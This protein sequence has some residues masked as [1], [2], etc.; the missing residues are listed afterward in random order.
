[1]KQR[2]GH[3]SALKIT[4]GKTDGS[5]KTDGNSFLMDR[6]TVPLNALKSG[7]N[8]GRSLP[9]QRNES[10]PGGLVLNFDNAD[11]YEVVRTMAEI[12]KINYLVE[13]DISGA[14]TIHTA[15]QLK[16]D[17]LFYVFYQ[18]LEINGLT[19]VR[20]GDLYRIVALNEASRMP[21]GLRTS[22]D[23]G[24]ISHGERVIIQIVPLKFISAVEMTKIITPFISADGTIVSQADSNMMLL[25]DKGTNID[26]ALRLVKVFD[27]DIFKRVDHRL[28]T[29][30]HADPTEIMQTLN[31]F[32]TSYGQSLGKD[33]KLIE[34]GRLNAIMAISSKSE[35]FDK[36][37][38]LISLLDV[39]VDGY[40]PRIFIYNVRNGEASELGDLLS[41]IFS[42]K[43]ESPSEDK[44]IKSSSKKEPSQA[45]LPV[46]IVSKKE[47]NDPKTKARPTPNSISG[48]SSLNTSINI[49]PDAIR[50]ALIIEATPADYQVVLDV[51]K[52]LDVLPRQVLIEVTLAEVT[53]NDSSSLGV[54]WTFIKDGGSVADGLIQGTLGSTNVLQYNFGNTQKWAATLTALAS[55]GDVNIL[56]S[57]SVLASDNKEAKIDISTE[58]PVVTTEYKYGT[59]GDDML[60]T[61]IQYRN[62]GVILTV[63]P[64]INE[65]GL[66]SMEINQEVSE[67]ADAV[68]AGGQ[69]Y[70]S[71]YK[72]SVQ[73][74]LTV[75]DNQTIAIGGLMRKKEEDS[76]AGIPLLN[77]LP[78]FKYLFGKTAGGNEKNELII[79]ITPR[80]VSDL[81]DIDQVTNEF[82]QR[83]GNTGKILMGT[84]TYSGE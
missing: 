29:M 2:A 76:S 46:Q 75:N 56:S 24:E 42:G 83:V 84:G 69:E 6:E 37:D 11:L 13:K 63:T 66:V 35:I 82:R 77:Q 12:L 7:K 71:F 15:G 40:E 58:V 18:I 9:I 14:V 41:T 23:D 61:N 53:L 38:E 60:A 44:N 27:V 64:H 72:R 19:A 8:S 47:I 54:E 50:N 57:P 32:F 5:E 25:V 1:M 62:T 48:S 73:T 30:A 22:T 68:L 59:D 78:F 79:L 51:L 10:K 49:I 45:M 70:P 31:Q 28:Y 21:I 67:Q 74:T 16:R 52:R 4:E 36:I 33:V 26:K 20:D 65:R 81:D 3:G 80:V 43:K 34:L 55:K 39:P 17:E